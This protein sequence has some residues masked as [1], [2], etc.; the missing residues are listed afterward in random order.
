VAKVKYK[1]RE[2]TKADLKR[3]VRRLFKLNLALARELHP[4]REFKK[5]ILGQPKGVRLTRADKAGQGEA[6]RGL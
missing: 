3:T 2:S 5:A 1:R 4:W 6:R